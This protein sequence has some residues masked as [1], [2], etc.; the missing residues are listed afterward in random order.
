MLRAAGIGADQLSEVRD[1]DR[2]LALVDPG[3]ERRWPVLAGAL[4]FAPIADGFASNLGTGA[5]DETT[6]A[7]AA[8]TS[9]AIR[10]L[11][12]DIPERIPPGTL[13]LPRR[14]GSLPARWCAQ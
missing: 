4:W 3:V 5:H 10:M 13:V 14:C 7:V 8:A 9:G 11:V 12:H 2:P 1:P 6:A